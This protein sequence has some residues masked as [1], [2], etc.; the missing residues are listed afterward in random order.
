[1][2]FL[3]FLFAAR[4]KKFLFSKINLF[5]ARCRPGRG[6]NGAADNHRR[7]KRCA[8]QSRAHSCAGANSGP[9]QGAL[10][11]IVAACRHGKKEARRR[12]A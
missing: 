4:V 7:Q 9:A 10:A 3:L 6:T 8:Q 2:V 11:R 5:V 1:M 12:Q